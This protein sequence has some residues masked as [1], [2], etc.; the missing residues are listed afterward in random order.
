MKTFKDYSKKQ[1][2]I[3]KITYFILGIILFLFGLLIM[4]FELFLGLIF[5]A[6]GI[7][8]FLLSH[9]L[10]ISLKQAKKVVQKDSSETFKCEQSSEQNYETISNFEIALDKIPQV[11][12]LPNINAEKLKRN[13]ASE[14][15]ELKFSNITKSTP[16]IRLSDFVVIDLETTGI[17]VS[18]RIIEI[19]ALKFQDFKPIE[20]FTTLINPKRSIPAEATKINNITDEM[21]TDAPELYQIAEQF[22]NFVGKNPIVAHNAEFDI[23]HLYA[24]GINLTNNK[25][26]DTLSLSQKTLKQFNYNSATWAIDHDKDYTYD[27]DNYKLETLIQYYG[28]YRSESHR[29]VSDCLATGFLFE[30]LCDDKIE[31]FP[32]EFCN[33]ILRETKVS[34]N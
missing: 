15:P 29:A 33:Y 25:I 28:L 8:C 10:G 2:K 27:V 14:I 3:W 20:C 30:E 7:F 23:R 12:I 5:L 31:E 13:L 16:L 34:K 17:S 19:C 6:G 22:M 24:S 1:I 9:A 11:D 21:V 4:Q 26:Y 32:R 18:N